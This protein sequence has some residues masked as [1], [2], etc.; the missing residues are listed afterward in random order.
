MSSKYQKYH[1]LLISCLIVATISIWG[2]TKGSL[3]LDDYQNFSPFLNIEKPNYSNI[4]FDNE[5]G[6]LGRSVSMA[7]FAFN[8][9]LRG[10]L[11]S[12][13]LKLTNLL[14]HLGNAL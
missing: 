11:N 13:D 12:Y 3:V 7:T 14:I 10:S 9:W 6:P 8:H 4:I 5:S 1:I 2:G